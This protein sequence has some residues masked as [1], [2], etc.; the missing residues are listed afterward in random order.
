MKEHA[1]LFA[2]ARKAGLGLTI[3][4]GETG[5]LEELRYVVREIRPERIG[6][7][8]AA[9]R[10]KKLMKEMAKQGVVV[11]MCPTSN[12]RNSVVKDIAQLC[13]I[14][15]AFLDAGIKVTINTDGPEMYCTSVLKEEEFLLAEGIMDEKEVR[16]CQRWAFAASFVRPPAKRRIL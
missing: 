16:Q 12:L 2:K 1:P 11:E 5:D 10:D 8:L 15:R 14:T 4:A 3:H 13:D 6:H 9:V 7:A